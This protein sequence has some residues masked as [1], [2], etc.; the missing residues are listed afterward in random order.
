LGTGIS[1]QDHNGTQLDLVSRLRQEPF[2]SGYCVSTLRTTDALTWPSF[3]RAENSHA[4]TIRPF[5]PA[6]SG[7]DRCCQGKEKSGRFKVEADLVELAEGTVTF[8]KSNG[9]TICVP[10]EKL[11]WAGQSGRGQEQTG[12]IALW[13]GLAHEEGEFRRSLVMRLDDLAPSGRQ[14]ANRRTFTRGSPGPN[15]STAMK[16]TTL[17]RFPGLSHRA[18]QHPLDLSAIA[19]IR[20]IPIL[21]QVLRKLSAAWTE[22]WVRLLYTADAVRVGPRQYPNLHRRFLEMAEILDV[23]SLPELFIMREDEINAVAIGQEKY[24]IVVNTGLIDI[25]T[26]DELLAVIAHELGHIKCDHMLYENL[27]AFLTP[28]VSAASEATFGVGQLV[29]IPLQLALFEWSRKAELSCDRAAL[30]ATQDPDTVVGVITKLTGAT[31]LLGDSI[32]VDE[33]VKQADEFTEMGT[34]SGLNQMMMLRLLA[35]RTHPHG[36][37]R[38]R[39]IRNWSGSEDWRRILAG[40]YARDQAPTLVSLTPTPLTT[41]TGLVCPTCQYVSPAGMTFC[42]KCRSN[43]RLAAIVCGS[44]HSPIQ[45][46]WLACPSCG[47]SLKADNVAAPPPVQVMAPK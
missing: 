10:L 15:P 46:S 2:K 21:P 35:A 38:T 26:D 11:S 43:L 29:M 4:C 8:K 47:H 3:R 42:A 44:C 22:R 17:R 12:R 37:V 18:F 1:T 39:E 24:F 28:L 30:L 16:P 14:A 13:Q 7:R 27:T 9:Q 25:L 36:V 6:D 40:D 23:R 41:P 20:S 19:A 33:L 34:Q 32:N 5:P 31:E 45:P